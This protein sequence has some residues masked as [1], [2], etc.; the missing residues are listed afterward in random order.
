MPA[1]APIQTDFQVIFS[2]EKKLQE[3]VAPY[4][5]A[6][7]TEFFQNKYGISIEINPNLSEETPRVTEKNS[8]P[9]LFFET[10]YQDEDLTV[11]YPDSPRVPHQLSVVL[12]RQVKGV[13]NLTSQEN[14]KLYHLIKR[15]NEIY[16]NQLDLD[17]FVLAQYSD[18]QERHHNRT[19]IELLPH[20]PGF[21]NCR[22][23]LD[24]ADSN[25]YVLFGDQSLT[26]LD[27]SLSEEEKDMQISFWKRELN[28][29]QEKISDDKLRLSY[30]YET[31]DTQAE[32]LQSFVVSNIVKLFENAGAQ[33]ISSSEHQFSY[34]LNS[35][36]EHK[37]R[38]V[39]DCA[40]CRDQVINRQKV[41]EYKDAY[42][43]YNFR[44]MPHAASS[45]LILPKEHLEKMYL[46]SDEKVHTLS[47]LKKALINVLKNKFPDFEVVVYN[48]DS[49]SVGQTV[50]HTHDQ[51]VAIDP[52]KVPFY[53]SMM[54]L[55]YNP[56]NVSGGVSEDEMSTVT[57]EIGELL[58]A[59]VL[60]LESEENHHSTQ[61]AFDY[62]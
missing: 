19:V 9:N 21:N 38:Q 24:K 2:D 29:D 12:N 39:F 45:F 18:P 34:A 1:L 35:K 26:S 61:E 3:I 25:R 16:V 59:E 27:L 58:N 42:V 4:S 8:L 48:Q 37:A 7:V 43:L 28:K 62:F 23:F 53:W 20:Q 57:Q 52:K 56:N 5:K 30:P 54:S 41:L 44:K 46:L 31:F 22:N 13:Q 49:P 10:V 47:L 60:R 33:I 55:A 36:T 51:V 14:L 11:F 40:F 50:F 32:E 15:V 17:G 6:D